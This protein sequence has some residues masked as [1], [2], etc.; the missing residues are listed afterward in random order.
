MI[1]AWDK[2]TKQPLLSICIPTYNRSKYLRKS[3]ESIISQEEFS[4]GMVEIVIS[5][6]ASEDDTQKIGMEFSEKYENIHYHRNKDN[7]RDKNFPIV[8]SE[9]NGVLRRLSNDTV[10]Y[11]K[12][13][14]KYICNII[15]E[16]KKERPVIFWSGGAGKSSD[17]SKKVNFRNF[18]QDVSYGMTSIL[19]FSIWEDECEDI[20][21]DS[22]GCELQLWQVR[23]ILEL[24][25]RKKNILI[26]N[27]VLTR[28]QA[29]EKKNISYGLYKVFYQNYFTLLSPYFNNKSLSMDDREYLEKDLL[30]CFFSE[31]CIKWE[32]QKD[33]FQFSQT[34]NLK[35]AVMQQ[36][37][38]KPYWNE[39]ENYYQIKLEKTKRLEEERKEIAE[40]IYKK[41]F[42]SQ[43]DLR[44]YYEIMKQYQSDDTII[45]LQQVIEKNYYKLKYLQDQ[46]FDKYVIWGTG[47]GGEN[48]K[49]VMDAFLN[50]KCVGYIDSFKSG[51]KDGL[52]VYK[53]DEYDFES[54]ENYII[55]AAANAE[56]IIS[57][58]LNKK[59]L[60]ELR[61][62]MP[63]VLF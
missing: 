29:V 34:E 54:K 24:A 40:R 12:N 11:K 43:I 16:N 47:N 57:D 30:F 19:T 55:V 61:D 2:L 7:V 53:A 41:I 35:D 32:L 18:V 62:Y 59:G 20:E 8:L 45:G 23:K 15:E 21:N 10:L 60:V 50:K 33:D 39:Y 25:Y 63:Q 26:C 27:K 36:Y 28:G 3:I 51:E 37:K 31:W 38:D 44:S 14:L 9:A 22:D 13:S 5:D 4:N 58:E 17:E 49:R 52:P 46:R 42:D 56:K 1:G 6:N 48:V